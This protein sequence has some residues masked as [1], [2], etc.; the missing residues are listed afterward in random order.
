MLESLRPSS[1]QF[2]VG[3][4]RLSLGRPL[5]M[6]I[7]NI[8]PDSFF[9][10]GK[11]IKPKAAIDYA[12]KL[13]SEGVDILDIGGE[14]SRPGAVPVPYEE[15]RRRV[16]PV[17]KEILKFNVPVSVDTYKPSLM[18]EVL[19]EGA[20]M[21]NDIYGFRMPGALRTV[22]EFN[23]GICI[24]HMQNFPRIMQNSPR[25]ENVLQ[26]VVSFFRK[27]TEAAKSLGISSERIV[28]DPGFGFGKSYQDNLKIFRNL[29]KFRALSYPI[30]VG[31]SRKSFLG[32]ITGQAVKN[33]EFAS[34]AAALAAVQKG[35]AILRIHDV[36]ATK[37]VLSVFAELSKWG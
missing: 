25:Y 35:G 20:S 7:I 17:L 27:Q 19:E 22:S 30:L 10:G 9:D 3:Q 18:K 32:Q 5:L 12:A 14:S 16:L 2:Q 31:V 24:M 36:Q 34:V 1:N 13:L 15:E 23:A 8:S 33:R 26:E 6:G 4:F 28:L 29:D 37:D 21:I 11:Y